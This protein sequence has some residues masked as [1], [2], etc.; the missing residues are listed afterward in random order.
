[1]QYDVTTFTGS[2]D[3]N[4]SKFALP[5]GGVMPW[6]GDND[7]SSTFATAVGAN[8]GLPNSYA[9]NTSGPVFA[10]QYITGPGTVTGRNWCTVSCMQNP[11][12]YD[13]F[14]NASFV[15]AQETLYTTPVPAPL[16]LLGSAAAL[17]FC[18]R[19]RSRS[20]R[21]RHGASRLA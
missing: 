12:Y 20:K 18:R 21:L 7:L 4:T 9:G 15:Y 2:Y 13:A 16:P 8:L 19:L 1:V 17:G 5:P 6:W 3:A 14:S 10:Y 11:D